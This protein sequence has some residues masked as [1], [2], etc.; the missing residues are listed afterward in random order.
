MLCISDTKRESSFRIR[1]VPSSSLSLPIGR[2]SA[3]LY[4]IPSL[5]LYGTARGTT[6]CS[7]YHIKGLYDVEK[8]IRGCPFWDETFKGYQ[9]NGKWVSDDAMEA[10][11]EEYFPDDIPD[12]WT[13]EEKLKSH[14]QGLLH[15]GE[16]MTLYRYAKIHFIK[17]ARFIIPTATLI[18]RKKIEQIAVCHPTAGISVPVSIE[19]NRKPLIRKYVR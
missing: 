3:R 9:K 5:A 8:G 14:G 17:P 10:Y 13:K 2:K 15:P 11:Y 4:A 1:P 16:V 19:I 12:E 18:D 7:H 6:L